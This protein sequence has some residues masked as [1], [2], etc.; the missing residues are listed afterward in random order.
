MR[1]FAHRST[2]MIVVIAFGLMG[3][4]I[5]FCQDMI[6]LRKQMATPVSSRNIHKQ[7][8]VEIEEEVHPAEHID[9][10]QQQSPTNNISMN[11][12]AEKPFRFCSEKDVY[13]E[14]S[15]RLPVHFP[16]KGDHYDEF[17]LAMRS[18]AVTLPEPMGCRD[19]PV[20]SNKN[21]LVMG[22]SH[23]R[24]MCYS[25]IC[26]YRNEVVEFATKVG[27]SN[28]TGSIKVRFANNSTLVSITNNPIVDSPEWA[29]LIEKRFR[30]PLNSYDGI[31]LGK[32]NVIRDSKPLTL[33]D[34]ANVY[35]GPVVYVSMFALKGNAELTANLEFI[36]TV[37]STRHNL[38]TISGRKYINRM[39]M[40]CGAIGLISPG[41]CYEDSDKKAAGKANG[42]HRCTGSQGGHPDLIAWEVAEKLNAL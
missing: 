12:K 35:H 31:V 5:Y 9:I 37:N 13:F 6:S 7:T 23:T 28:E 16:C 24:Q 19:F 41:P 32:L 30:R 22:N 27:G 8:E 15:Q 20:A 10:A 11:K 39:K 40:E 2:L 17:A 26:Q 42:M 33:R 34:V 29:S 18:L 14:K 25:L 4:I 36:T 38:S 21:V 1:P 3:G